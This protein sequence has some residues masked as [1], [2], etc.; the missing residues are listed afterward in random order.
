MGLTPPY[1]EL[2][3]KTLIVRPAG[4]YLDFGEGVETFFPSKVSQL[5]PY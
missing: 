4:A 3:Y 5:L 1:N 2:M